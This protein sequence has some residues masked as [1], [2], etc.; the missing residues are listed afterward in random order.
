MPVLVLAW[1]GDPVH[2]Q[3]TAERLGELL[4][5][6]EVVVAPTL[7]DVLAWSGRVREFL[8]GVVQPT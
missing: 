5:E 3:A 4:P 7:R 2:P 6:A 1:E 8:D